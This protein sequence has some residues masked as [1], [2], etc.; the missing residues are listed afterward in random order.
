[1]VLPVFVLPLAVALFF[2]LSGVVGLPCVVVTVRAIVVTVRAIVVTVRAIVVTVHAVVVSVRAVVVSVPAVVVSVSVIVVTVPAV[3]VTVSAI[4]FMVPAV[5]VTV[6]FV[7]PVFLVAQSDYFG[8]PSFGQARRE[9]VALKYD[10]RATIAR[11]GVP[12]LILTEIVSTV[13]AKHVV[14]D[15]HRHLETE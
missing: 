3:V 1:L 10:P 12:D 15:T 8:V 9:P 7:A 5:V 14:G 13:D 2:C 11:G 4:V 6:S